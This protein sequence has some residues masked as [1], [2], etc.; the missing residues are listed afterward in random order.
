M[1]LHL[2]ATNL[3]AL[4]I[5][6]KSA[7]LFEISALYLLWDVFFHKRNSLL[8]FWKSL[9]VYSR[10]FLNNSLFSFTPLTLFFL[11]PYA[12]NRGKRL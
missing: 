1:L 12:S 2:F 3:S 6:S 4:S 11:D 9:L 8:Q 5:I 10:F 7:C